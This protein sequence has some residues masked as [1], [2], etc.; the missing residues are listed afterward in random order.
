MSDDV[1]TTHLLSH[2]TEFTLVELCR[3][4][5]LSAEQVFAL[6]EE[7]VIEPR[8]ANP[9][10]WRF[11]A[12]CVKRVQRAYRLERDLGVNMAGAALIIDLIEEIEQLKTRLRR[13][14]RLE[15]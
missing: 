9:G 1:T 10:Q 11:R 13:L 4:C 6:V 3:S 14:E 15:S 2:D 8:G 5:R 7:G 12:I